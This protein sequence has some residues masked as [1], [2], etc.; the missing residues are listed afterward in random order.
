MARG[1]SGRIVIEIDPEFKER[2]YRVLYSDGVTLKEWFLLN[3]ERFLNER[4][5]PSL[6][7]FSSGS[8]DLRSR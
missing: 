2:L 3:A 7:G 5:Q 4:S 6:F 1:S 8:Q